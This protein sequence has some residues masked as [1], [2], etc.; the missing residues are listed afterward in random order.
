[1]VPA[2]LLGKLHSLKLTASLTPENRPFDP[3]GNSFPTI[4][5]PLFLEAMLVLGYA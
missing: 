4:R 5:N 2:F 3:K 1:M